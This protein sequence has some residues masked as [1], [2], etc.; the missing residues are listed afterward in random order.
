MITGVREFLL[1]FENMIFQIIEQNC[2][3]LKCMVFTD[4]KRRVLLTSSTPFRVER[5]WATSGTAE[6]FFRQ[7]LSRFHRNSSPETSTPASHT[8]E[9]HI[10]N[11]NKLTNWQHDGNNNIPIIKH[12][13]ESSQTTPVW[14]AAIVTT[15][16]SKGCSLGVFFLVRPVTILISLIRWSS[17]RKTDSFSWWTTATHAI[18]SISNV[19]I[20]GLHSSL[21]IN[22][23]CY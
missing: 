10:N 14:D 22:W 4:K 9:E 21:H 18:C 6:A 20:V 15:L 17:N 7:S 5:S 23:N 19:P 12:V 11:N 13:A 8:P 3:W 16:F 2:Y 1:P